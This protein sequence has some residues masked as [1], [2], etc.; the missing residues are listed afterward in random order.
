VVVINLGS[1]VVTIVVTS[2]GYNLVVVIVVGTILVSV[3]AGKVVVTFLVNTV[4]TTSVFGGSVTIFV[5]VL[6]SNKYQRSDVIPTLRMKT[7]KTH[8]INFL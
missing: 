8:V 1:V 6:W 5:T 3:T 2:Y 4:V 7:I